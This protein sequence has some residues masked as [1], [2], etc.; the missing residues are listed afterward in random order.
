MVSI[1]FFFITPSHLSASVLTRASNSLQHINGKPIRIHICYIHRLCKQFFSNN[2]PVILYCSQFLP[3]TFTLHRKWFN[4]TQP[5]DYVHM[6][7]CCQ[8]PLSDYSILSKTWSKCK[9]F[10]S[11]SRAVICVT[12]PFMLTP[13]HFYQA[14]N[15]DFAYTGNILLKPAKGRESKDPLY[16]D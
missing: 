7:G 8:T 6:S 1:I 10:S 5:C 15:I 12:E 16:T 2:F 11:F 14:F 13:R 4:E 3:V 9:Q